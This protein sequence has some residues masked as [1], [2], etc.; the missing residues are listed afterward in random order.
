[1]GAKARLLVCIDRCLRAETVRRESVR[2]VQAFGPS[3]F[4]ILHPSRAGQRFFAG[5]HALELVPRWREGGRSVDPPPG[6]SLVE[7]GI[8]ADFYESGYERGNPW[9]IIAISRW[10][11][12]VWPTCTVLYTSD[13]GRAPAP[14]DEESMW[15]HFTSERGRAY[16]DHR[17]VT[18]R[19]GDFVHCDFCD[20][21]TARRG[22]IRTQT[23]TADTGFECPGCG[24]CYLRHPDGSAVRVDSTFNDATDA[25]QR[26]AALQVA[27]GAVE[28][29]EATINRVRRTF[30]RPGDTTLELTITGEI[31]DVSRPE[32]F[33]RAAMGLMDR[34]KQEE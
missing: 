20:L 21:D 9:E 1:M 17:S 26:L 11:R 6:G 14:I 10:I 2:L 33:E 5:R 13:T 34:I 30:N 27:L 28:C 16:Y 15:R 32:L 29:G 3:M 18:G 25:D 8:V 22:G 12:G 23:G 24:A 4:E 31:A 19:R 7:V